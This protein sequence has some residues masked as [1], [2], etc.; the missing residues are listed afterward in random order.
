MTIATLTLVGC[1]TTSGPDPTETELHAVDQRLT[2]VEHDDENMLRL[3][4]RIDSLE[5][6]QRDLRGM[7]EELQNSNETL[8]KQQRDLYADLERRLA[9]VQ[10]AGVAGAGVAGAGVAGA[11]VAGAGVAGAGVAAGAV[12]GAAAGAA[13]GAAAGGGVLSDGGEQGAYTHAFDALK[14]NDYSTAI[15]RL[16]EF[17]HAYPQSSL[18]G[19]AQYWLGQA[20]YVTGD[21]DDAAASFRAV[22][23]QYPNSPKVPDA[24]LKLGMTQVDQKKLTDA[25]ATLAQVVQKYPGTDAA[26][27][28]TA[29]LQNLPPD[30]H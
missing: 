16:R 21:L 20:Y 18:A 26:R 25:H 24:L 6:Q 12:S 7:I 30:A 13:V 14:S 27:L 1:E 28:A 8:R 5:N 10:G 3:S 23:E 17:L 11:G 4:A 9:A 15:T 29:R 19:N 2:R 22:G